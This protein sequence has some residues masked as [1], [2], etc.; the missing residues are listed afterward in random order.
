[1]KKILAYASLQFRDK[2]IYGVTDSII[3]VA[4]SDPK[5]LERYRTSIKQLRLKPRI[6]FAT[7]EEIKSEGAMGS[8][9]LNEVE[10]K[11]SLRDL[12]FCPYSKEGRADENYV[13]R[14]T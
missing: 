10:E 2:G 11:Y 13:F 8:I 14:R 6:W 9:W 4:G 5:W 7:M 3:L 12:S 1:M